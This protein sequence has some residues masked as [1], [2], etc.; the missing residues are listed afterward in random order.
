M[1]YLE[2]YCLKT[3]IQA[4]SICFQRIFLSGFAQSRNRI[5]T[6]K[7]R[8]SPIKIVVITNF[9][10]FIFTDILNKKPILFSVNF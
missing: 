10:L 8:K 2:N 7:F 6:R 5:F 1:E 9:S 3:A 4:I